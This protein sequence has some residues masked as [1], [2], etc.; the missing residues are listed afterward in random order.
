MAP[1][2][3]TPAIMPFPAVE[4]RPPIGF[5][6]GW[7]RP[8]GRTD[9]LRE[10]PAFCRG[11][12]MIG[13]VRYKKKEIQSSPSALRYAMSIVVACGHC[14]GSLKI[15]EQ[16]LGKAV[17]CPLCQ[18][19]FIAQA[20]T[21]PTP[22][23]EDGTVVAA[24]TGCRRSLKIARKNLG[25]NML[26]PHCK[27]IFTAA[28]GANG[29][30]QRAAVGQEPSQPA[31]TPSPF[32]D[33]GP[34]PRLADRPP[35]GSAKK[36]TPSSRAAD[37]DEDRSFPPVKFTVVVK[38]DP[39]K[40]LKGQFHATATRD[41]LRLQQGKMDLQAPIG[42]E[43]RYRREN[44]LAVEIE[45]RLVDLA[46]TSFMLYRERLARDLAEFLQGERRTLDPERYRLPWYLFAPAVLPVGIPMLT[47]GGAIPGAIG[48][49]LAGV[50]FGIAQRDRWNV[51]VRL[52]AIIS[53]VVAGYL[54]F[55][56]FLLAVRSNQG[57]SQSA[58]KPGPNPPRPPE[59]PPP[60]KDDG[61]PP[62]KKEDP[63]TKIPDAEGRVF[64]PGEAV[65]LAF[66]PRDPTTLITTSR[67]GTIQLWNTTEVRATA[68][69][70]SQGSGIE[71]TG[72]AVSPDGERAFIIRHGGSLTVVNLVKQ[73]W[74]P[75]WLESDPAMI[76][77]WG[78]AMARDGKTLATAHGDSVVKL[79]DVSMGKVR[80]TLGGHQDQVHAVAFAPDNATIATGDKETVSLWNAQTGTKT[81]SFRAQDDGKDIIPT[82]LALAFS[83]DGKT[84]AAA[85]NDGSIRLRDLAGNSQKA[86][87]TQG[88][89]VGALAF[90][91]DGARLASAGWGG[92]VILWDVARAA[93]LAE[94]DLQ[95]QQVEGL[96]FQP[97]GLRL[98]ITGQRVILW[99]APAGK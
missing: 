7:N 28:A 2:K 76:A 66:S 12:V 56:I 36:K 20:Q 67:N 23:P 75:V 84:L 5:R 64:L 89:P 40:Q 47:L 63:P 32:P 71:V 93:K 45:G 95:V 10:G 88:F 83:P 16:G 33:L 98:A 4:S 73:A 68:T 92:K 18:K 3:N 57:P 85:G 37:L 8:S 49:G 44:I 19:N 15:P 11:V 14:G 27:T 60:G 54:G 22:D 38:K 90:S 46:V 86:R 87:L 94:L 69:I 31:A 34:P 13:V 61:N 51:G 17:K 39:D 72:L 59:V 77:Q 82:V 80:K 62:I 42:I 65:A 55:G 81:G 58:V 43:T 6:I 52:T 96:A 53:L 25:R 48:F 24:C 35:S 9:C 91:S 30:E 70:P 79:W 41:G 78:V 21:S 99:D 97:G 29:Q 26:C 1:G 74:E 50:C